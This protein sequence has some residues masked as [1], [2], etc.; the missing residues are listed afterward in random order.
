MCDGGVGLAVTGE[1]SGAEF[2]SILV[3]MCC[4]HTTGFGLPVAA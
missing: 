3:M 1:D 2:G 4:V